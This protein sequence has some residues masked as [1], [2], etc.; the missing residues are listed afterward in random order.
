MTMILRRL[1]KNFSCQVL[2]TN[3]AAGFIRGRKYDTD[4]SRLG[5]METS[6]RELNQVGQLNREM[7][8][9]KTE[10][11]AASSGRITSG[12]ND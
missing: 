6:Q 10:L 1:S 8:K 7:R 11:N 9:L 3:G 2:N 4:L 5:K 12:D